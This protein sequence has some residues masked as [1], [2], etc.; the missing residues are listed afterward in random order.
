LM[1]NFS[2]GT[3]RV[4]LENYLEHLHKKYFSVWA[5]NSWLN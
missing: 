1:H 3:K 4:I 2:D 5:S